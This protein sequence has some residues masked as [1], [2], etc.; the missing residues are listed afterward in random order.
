[1]S[2][3]GTIAL[4]GLLITYL[5]SFSPKSGANSIGTMLGGRLWA[6]RAPD[7]AAYPFGVLRLTGREQFGD[8]A[9]LREEGR[10]ELQ[11]FGRPLAQASTVEAVCD[12]AE[13]A[14]LKYSAN[15]GGLFDVRAKVS[16]D[17][18]PPPPSPGDREIAQ[19]RVL[20]SYS[21][22]PDYRTQYAVAVGDAP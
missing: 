11:V 20:W 19:A 2:D 1:M 22:W 8:D 15:Y 10:I 7:N 9:S 14:F 13:A 18:L 3:T 6:I 17:T 4:Q 16:R 21:W 5:K 12:I